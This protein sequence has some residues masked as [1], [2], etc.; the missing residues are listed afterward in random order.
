MHAEKRCVAGDTVVV[1]DERL[2]LGKASGA[3][4]NAADFSEGSRA[5]AAL[6]REN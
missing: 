5:Q 1:G 3:N 6:V 4:G 2:R